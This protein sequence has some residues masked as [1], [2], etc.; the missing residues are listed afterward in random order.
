MTQLLDDFLVTTSIETLRTDLDWIE[1]ALGFLH[2]E[3]TAGNAILG[4]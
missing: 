2:A 1:R 4:F 3:A